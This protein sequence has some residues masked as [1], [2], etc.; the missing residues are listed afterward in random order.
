M[1]WVGASAL[2]RMTW[3]GASAPQAK[4]S[5]PYKSLIWCFMTI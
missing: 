3:V 5:R 1:T 4:Q 2:Y